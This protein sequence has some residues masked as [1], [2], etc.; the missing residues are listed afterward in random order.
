MLLH[1]IDVIAPRIERGNTVLGS[2]GTVVFV[3]IVCANH[4]HPIVPEDLGDSVGQSRLAGGGIAHDT[5][6]DRMGHTVLGH[7]YLPVL[8]LDFLFIISNSRQLA[9]SW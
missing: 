2:L 3:V 5:E 9:G 6:N 7:I 8:N 1:D 4:G